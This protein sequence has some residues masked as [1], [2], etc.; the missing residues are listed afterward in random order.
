VGSPSF[1][2]ASTFLANGQGRDLCDTIYGIFNDL[3]KNTYPSSGAVIDARG[4]S[5]ATNLTCTRGTPWTE[6]SN[7]VS[8]PSTILLPATTGAAPIVI[9]S[10]WFLPPNTHLIGEGDSITSGGFTPGTTLLA[11]TNFTSG[12]AMISFGQSSL[13]TSTCSGIS[14]ENLTLNG[15]GQSIDGIDNGLSQDASYVDHVSL[16]RI[17]GTGAANKT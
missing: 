10:T 4:I 13:C 11:A 12:T 9:P 3:F 7:T 14:V 5:G 15:A 8:V 16:F 17:R 2:D 1:I 6:G